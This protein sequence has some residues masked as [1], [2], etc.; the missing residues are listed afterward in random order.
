M[1]AGKAVVAVGVACLAS[2]AASDTAL[3]PIHIAH[4]AIERASLEPLPPL[5]ILQEASPAPTTPPITP[6]PSGFKL[7]TET[8]ADEDKREPDPVLRF[9]SRDLPRRVVEPI[10][11]AAI[12]T[13]VDPSYLM[14][15][16]DKESSFR[17]DVRASTSS[18]EGLYQFI[19]RTWLEVVQIF[20]P[21]HGLESEAAAIETVE[22][23]P[24][25]VDAERRA[26][27]LDLRRDP[28]LAAVMAAELLKRDAALI[29]F[30]IGRRLTRTELY[31]AHF[32]GLDDGAR[33]MA[34]KGAKKAANAAKAFPAAARAN[35]AIFFAAHKRGR[36]SLSVPEV[37]AR[38]DKM[39]EPRAERYQSVQAFAQAQL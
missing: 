31:I 28:Y 10:V 39:I 22:Q 6:A 7:R 29:G 32:L 34:L 23:R 33:F 8:R 20:G 37:Y 1:L 15:L 35:R 5:A 30:K 25:V 24:V 9:G 13:E 4:A 17:P 18:A 3:A 12:R 2:A 16:A 21:K 27:I 19:E 38:L 14:A 11:R 26:R 36:R